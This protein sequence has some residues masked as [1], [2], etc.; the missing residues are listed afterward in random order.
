[1]TTTERDACRFCLGAKGG[2]PGNENRIADIVVCDYCTSLLMD[3]EKAAQRCPVHYGQIHGGEAEELRAG[4]ESLIAQHP[5]GAVPRRKLQRLIDRIDARDSL[6]H[7]EMRD[8]E[9]LR[10]IVRRLHETSER[11]RDDGLRIVRQDVFDDL[12]ALVGGAK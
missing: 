8:G 7:L 6:A 9:P 10:D 2:T 5:D 3:M 1:M 4:I 12:L 11:S